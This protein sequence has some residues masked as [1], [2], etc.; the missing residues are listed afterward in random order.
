M[1]KLDKSTL[2]PVSHRRQ[3]VDFR[4][5][6]YRLNIPKT[7]GGRSTDISINGVPRAMNDILGV[8]FG[9]YLYQL[10]QQQ[11]NTKDDPTVFNKFLKSVYDN[12]A[13]FLGTETSPSYVDDLSTLGIFQEIDITPLVTR[14][15]SSL[16]VENPNQCTITAL[17]PAYA[18][19]S[20]L[21]VSK[22]RTNAG[23]FI[24]KNM[25][26]LTPFDDLIN[27]QFKEFDLVRVFVYSRFEQKPSNYISKIGSTFKQS[28]IT[29]V[30]NV[31]DYAMKP[32]FT[33]LVN[34]IAQ[35]SRT[36]SIST[37][38]VNCLGVSRM[39]M[40]SVAIFSHA[41][42]NQ[43]QASAS[44]ISILSN[45][46][47]VFA[48]DFTQQSGDDIAASIF[49]AYFHPAF[50]K[51]AND[52]YAAAVPSLATL[53][54]AMFTQPNT[55]APN[56][57]VQSSGGSPGYNMIPM[58]PTIVLLHLLK[59]KY[60]EPFLTID[61]RLDSFNDYV[62]SKS[63]LPMAQIAQ[64]GKMDS[65][66]NPYLLR[67]RDTFATYSSDYKSPME[68]FADVKDATYMEFFEDRTGQFHL[69]FPRYNLGDIVHSFDSNEIT[70]ST[71]IRDDSA[72]NSAT[73]A[74]P[75]FPIYGATSDVPP[76]VFI[77][78]F[79]VL[80][81]GFRKPN[82]IENPNN[83]DD[84]FCSAFAKFFRDY[85]AGK[86][87]RRAQIEKVGDVSLNVGEMVLFHPARKEGTSDHINSMTTS[88]FAG[89]VV[90]IH[91][92]IDVSG[93]Y[94]QHLDLDFVRRAGVIG[95]EGSDPQYTINGTMWDM[96]DLY[97]SNGTVS[98]SDIRSEYPLSPGSGDILPNVLPSDWFINIKVASGLVS[99]AEFMSIADP[100]DLAVITSQHQSSQDAHNKA[101]L[102]TGGNKPLSSSVI[103]ASIK[104]L[105]Q[106]IADQTKI[107]AI[108]KQKAIVYGQIQAAVQEGENTIKSAIPSG[109]RFGAHTFNR[110]MF[111]D[112]S[113]SI[114]GAA[115]TASL[116]ITKPGSSVNVG[117][118]TATGVTQTT[119][120]LQFNNS[121]ISEFSLGSL[122]ANID[123]LVGNN[124]EA[125]YRTIFVPNNINAPVTNQDIA[126]ALDLLD[127]MDK[128][129]TIAISQ[130]NTTVTSDTKIAE[131]QSE[132]AKQNDAMSSSKQSESSSASATALAGAP[133]QGTVMIN[134]TVP[135]NNLDTS[136]ANSVSIS[137][138][139]STQTVQP[140]NTVN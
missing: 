93:E 19:F 91:E 17:D 7:F 92:T 134:A 109:G 119:V 47:S 126:E 118:N 68:V 69:R 100:V 98:F 80:R 139:T 84:D 102:N 95:G 60:R 111:V 20:S 54:R 117:I 131:L 13:I 81:Y 15:E 82:T 130:L 14:V 63:P 65:I 72:V 6:V 112:V 107:L 97:G 70:E 110:S 37:L 104:S 106:Q 62:T 21:N 10:I 132:I 96:L 25:S 4:V 105:N 40:Q 5:V 34:T 8:D 71:Y 57:A 29:P 56:Q 22:Q 121:S 66:L 1:K 88:V 114:G 23:A 35:R 101:L 46:F 78:K 94:I 41:L 53:L 115:S 3:Y 50:V 11:L 18:D 36:N 99:K 73:V 108:A 49:R 24:P 87:S 30:A 9:D 38:V 74:Q 75:M 85:T 122:L 138:G 140:E 136:S 124:F 129:L 125:R 67:F 2:S 27:F 32:A 120:P 90:E 123:G 42:A 86:T 133:T 55:V 58:L 116:N 45:Q 137:Q 44:E 77:D 113:N 26:A 12:L 52:S 76:P 28:N 64:R 39:L 135:G 51:D 33:G 16:S 31:P 89:Y 48:N 79:S 43:V 128:E 103:S 61:D 83:T 59:L 127:T